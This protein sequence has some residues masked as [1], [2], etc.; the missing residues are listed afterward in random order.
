ML[1]EN[2]I[3]PDPW[4]RPRRPPTAWLDRASLRGVK[5]RARAPL[6]LAAGGSDGMTGRHVLVD[7]RLEEHSVVS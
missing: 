2:V 7:A 5:K 4:C 6:F 3:D 1:M